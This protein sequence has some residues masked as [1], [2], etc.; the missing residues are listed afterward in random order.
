MFPI[1]ETMSQKI[2][3]VSGAK[4]I[5]ELSAITYPSKKSKLEEVSTSDSFQQCAG[6]RGSVES[7]LSSTS[8]ETNLHRRK[9]THSKP[10]L[11]H[12]DKKETQR[13]PSEKKEKGRK[14]VEKYPVIKGGVSA[15]EKKPRSASLVEKV[16]KPFPKEEK[17][18]NSVDV[19][20][21]TLKVSGKIEKSCSSNASVNIEEK[22]NTSKKLKSDACLNKPNKKS[23]TKEPKQ[24]KK[25]SK[26][27]S[28]EK[29]KKDIIKVVDDEIS[30]KVSEVQ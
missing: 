3:E 7:L 8:S 19:K 20:L 6:R 28:I 4:T 25:P 15:V 5:E 18:R 27:S 29:K 22:S 26:I 12:A 23:N 14:S 10:T 17:R 2:L 21:P 1:G 24:Q 13:E 30:F 16:S 11:F 9:S